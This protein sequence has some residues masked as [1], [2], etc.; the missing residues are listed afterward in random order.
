[1][2]TIRVTLFGALMVLITACASLG[3]APAQSFDQRWAYANGTLTAVVQ[4]AS[5]GVEGG[6][7]S[8]DDG[9]AV[10]E[11]A[12]QARSL[13]DAAH[14]ATSVEDANRNLSLAVAVLENL[15]TYLNDRSK[16]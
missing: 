14:S 12:K 16:P 2:K 5:Q 15:Q 4:T 9:R 10:L 7:L 6:T 3:I 1:M 11:I 8:K 13:L